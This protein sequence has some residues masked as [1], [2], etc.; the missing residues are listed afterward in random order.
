MIDNKI[1]KEKRDLVI[2]DFDG[3][4]FLNPDNNFGF[5]M[6]INRVIDAYTFFN[7]FM[8][9]TNERIS[10]NAECIL[11]TGRIK[12]Q[13]GVITHLLELKGYQFDESFFNQGGIT[14]NIDEK[15]TF[16]TKYWN[17]KI[18]L[19][20]EIKSS[21]LYKSIVIIDDDAVLCSALTKLGFAV[22]KA[23][24][25][26]NSS[27]QSLTIKFSTPQERSMTELNAL[28]N[29]RRSQSNSVIEAV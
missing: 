23:Q 8:F 25:T 10:E 22:F 17:G 26:K 27:N 5:H 11:I 4:L 21:N 13:E 24:I 9:Q 29:P 12:A 16:M 3:T 14:N 18:K 1:D 6:P 7:E 28:L 15:E 20:N 19:I 2:I